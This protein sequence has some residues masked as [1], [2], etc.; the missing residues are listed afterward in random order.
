[1]E[2]WEGQA[3]PGNLATAQQQQQQRKPAAGSAEH[4]LAATIGFMSIN[5]IDNTMIAGTRQLENGNRIARFL[6]LHGN[7]NEI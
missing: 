4:E 7:H 5:L 6:S 1:M 2:S 3:W